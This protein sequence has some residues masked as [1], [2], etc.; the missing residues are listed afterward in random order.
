MVRY[1]IDPE[2]S[3][4]WVDAKSSLHAIHTE[5]NGLEGFIDAEVVDGGQLDLAVAPK[6]R[7]QFAIERLSSGNPL[8]D[9]EM[10]RR[11][12][13]ARYPTIVGELGTMKAL[14]EKGRFHVT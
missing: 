4:V 8:E 1:R 12:D 11:V 6:G 3:R 5:T 7:L 9:R 10:R 14:G 13:A 2:R